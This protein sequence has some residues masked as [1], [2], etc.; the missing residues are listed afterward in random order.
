MSEVTTASE[1]AALAKLQADYVKET[2]KRAMAENKV[3]ALE[4]TLKSLQEDL[5]SART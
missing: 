1:R 4:Q 2:K 3:L 5:G